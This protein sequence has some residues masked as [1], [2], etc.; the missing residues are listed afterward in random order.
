MD[1]NK[2]I[3]QALPYGPDFCFVD[4]IE[5]VNENQIVGKY[6]FR[7]NLAFYNSHFKNKPLVPGVLMVEAMG[8]IGMVSHLIY[9]TG[10]YKFNFLPVLS[11]IETE[12]YDN[13]SYD[14]ELTIT[15][16]KIYF[17]YNILKSSVEMRKSDNSLIAK[18]TAN[19]KII[20]EK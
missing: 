20:E 2:K 18:L 17:R 12:F 14:D 4:L 5:S 8:Q 1:I 11:N 3:L 19:I 13:A 6:T 16:K 9:L 15:G 10:D 7:K